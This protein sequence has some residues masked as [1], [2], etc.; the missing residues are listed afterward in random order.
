MMVSTVV[1]LTPHAITLV[2]GDWETTVTIPSSGVVRVEQTARTVDMVTIADGEH[3]IAMP[4][5]ATTFGAIT[6]LPPAVPD[7]IYIVSLIAAQRI[8]VEH[9]ERNDVFVVAD[10][11]RDNDG[12]IV[13]AR[14]L[15]RV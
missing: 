11:V 15:A 5:L 9:P 12:R 7:T 6:G 3:T 4:V 8:R 13:G 10:T 14:A 1:N 2:S